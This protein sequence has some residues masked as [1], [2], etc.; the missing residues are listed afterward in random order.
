MIFPIWAGQQCYV[1]FV[2]KWPGFEIIV[3]QQHAFQDAFFQL[4]GCTN[5]TCEDLLQNH[6]IYLQQSR[7]HGYGT[8][9][10]DNL[11]PYIDIKRTPDA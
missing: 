6:A 5:W 10:Y 1:A 3:K 2:L 4:E 7:P 9:V 8:A 11:M